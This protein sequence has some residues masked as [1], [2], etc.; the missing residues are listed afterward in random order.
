[1]N[2]VRWTGNATPA[3]PTTYANTAG[4]TATL[5]GGSTAAQ[6]WKAGANEVTLL[7]YDSGGAAVRLRV[8]SSSAQCPS[9]PVAITIAPAPTVTL[10]QP[11]AL[12][13]TTSG[14]ADGA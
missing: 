11:F 1:M 13:G 4:S 8:A 6:Q 14:L 12:S 9:G 5:G 3:L 10:A 7:V 2:G